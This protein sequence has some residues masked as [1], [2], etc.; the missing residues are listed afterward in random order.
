MQRKPFYQ[1]DRS[2][3]LFNPVQPGPEEEVRQW[4]LHELLRC[5]G[6]DIRRIK[7]ECEV[8][9][10][11]RYHRADIVI[12][13]ADNN[14]YCVIECK[15]LK[16]RKHEDAMEQA[17][18]Y[19]MAGKGQPRFV[20]Y[21]NGNE[22]RVKRRAENGWISVLDLP[23]F[24]DESPDKTFIDVSDSFTHLYPVL[25]WLDQSVPSK[26]ASKYFGALQI[27]INSNN[28]VFGGTNQ[29]LL[30]IADNICRA[31]SH[32][33]EQNSYAAE[34]IRTA[35]E[36]IRRITVERG[37]EM[38]EFLPGDPRQIANEARYSIS[39]LIKKMDGEQ[40]MDL[41]VMRVSMTLL[42][43]FSNMNGP[44]TYSNIESDI[45]HN[46]RAYLE[47]GLA[48]NFNLTLP[49]ISDTD[50]VGTL[51]AISETAWNTHLK[52]R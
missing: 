10:G 13:D 37:G 4:C 39:K 27:L 9:V 31:L 47:L 28:L 32:V 20:M 12:H 42:S 35:Y 11:R 24:G 45:Q 2:A 33:R 1:V 46:L 8:K 6:V 52:S 25:Y 30:F 48:K 36:Y 43:Y 15:A 18:S 29:D 19:A 7:T 23:D 38:P 21:T 17:I 44:F 40:G 5:Y 41:Q 51:R 50:G 49:K 34:K 26:F 14:P 3:W 22:W 16:E